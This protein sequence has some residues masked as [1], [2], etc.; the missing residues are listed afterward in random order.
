[1]F[2][3]RVKFKVENDNKKVTNAYSNLKK[4]MYYVALTIIYREF[5]TQKNK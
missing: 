5:K 4:K 3:K 1:M 2:T